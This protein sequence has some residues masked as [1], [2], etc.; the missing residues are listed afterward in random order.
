MSKSIALLAVMALALCSAAQGQSITWVEKGGTTGDLD[1]A[2]EP[3]LDDDITPEPSAAAK[4]RYLPSSI[5]LSILLP[6]EAKDL[7][8]RIRWGD[9]RRESDVEGGE[10]WMRKQREERL[11]LELKGKL[12]SPVEH[13]VPDGDGLRI[14]VMI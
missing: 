12:S 2:G 3:G 4:Q 6:K 8:V 7:D 1:A 5:G 13:K 14:A 9:Y 11:P 10:R